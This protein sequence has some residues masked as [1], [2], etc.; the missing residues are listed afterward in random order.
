MISEQNKILK[1]NP[2]DYKRSLRFKSYVEEMVD[3]LHR[4]R[5][6]LSRERIK[7]IVLEKAKEQYKKVLPKVLINDNEVDIHNMD[8]YILNNDLIVAGSGSLYVQHKGS[9]NIITLMIDYLKKQ[10]KQFKKQ[11]FESM[12]AGDEVGEQKFDILQLTMKIFNNSL[13]GVLTESNSIFYNPLSGPSITLSGQDATTTAVT[14]FEKF[15]ANNMFFWEVRDVLIY[16]NNIVNEE[17]KKDDIKFAQTKSVDFLV[18]YLTSKM[19]KVTDK[20]RNIIRRM[21]NNIDKKYYNRIYYK[22]NFN[23]FMEESNVMERYFNKVLGLENFLDANEPPK[24][25]E[26]DLNELWS[27]LEDHL[28]YNYQDFH[29]FENMFEENGR[30]RKRKATLTIDTDSNFLAMHSNM[31]CLKELNESLSDIDENFNRRLS[32]VNTIMYI[33]T[34]VIRT[35]LY[36]YCREVGIPHDKTHL[37]DMKNEFYMSRIML[38][39]NKK[40]YAAIVNAQEGNLIPEHRQFDMKG[41]AIKKVNTNKQVRNILSKTLEEKILKEKDIKVGSVVKVYK[42][43]ERQIYDSIMSGSLEFAIPDKVN[44]A[45]SYKFPY[46]IESFRGT[47]LWN[48]LFPNKLIN[49]PAK[50]K[51]VKLRMGLSEVM[52]YFKDD[53][54]KLELFRSIFSN[55]DLLIDNEINTLAVPQDVDTLPE[56]II[57]FVDVESQVNANIKAGL[58][59]LESIGVQTIPVLKHEFPTTRIKF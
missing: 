24:E 12:N 7:E 27:V 19:D 51:K 42:D 11:K 26:E 20:D 21:L 49:T 59:I 23:K 44:S 6:D 55:D 8:R 34:K 30:K 35:C 47:I 41:L 38:T 39:P 2:E 37:L 43:L 52:K 33:N 31:M 16:I 10:R 18:D 15:I 36:K 28:L 32:L 17:Y 3:L 46:R 14:V 5:P 9:V 40:N 57:P 58:I 29:R 56:F 50:V 54:E 13:Y 1:E 48:K 53:E 4:I 25:I 45:E 22:N